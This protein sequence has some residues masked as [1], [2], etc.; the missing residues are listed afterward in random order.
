[1]I[2]FRPTKAWISWL[3]SYANN[4][5]IVDIGCGDGELLKQL[6]QS[7]Y[8]NLIGVDLF[9]GDKLRSDLIGSGCHLLEMNTITDNL[10]A[11]MF[12]GNSDKALFLF[13][14]PCQGGVVEFTLPN[15][16]AGSEVLYVG[17]L[18]NLDTDVSNYTCIYPKLIESA[19]QL[20]EEKTWQILAPQQTGRYL[21]RT[22]Y[23]RTK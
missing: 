18:E 13:C 22:S 6:R 19:P 4:R 14:C 8:S 20:Y 11:S 21:K 12:D 9:I 15:L 5:I 3:I 1:M 16:P 2:F 10:L 23:G 17:K 7:G